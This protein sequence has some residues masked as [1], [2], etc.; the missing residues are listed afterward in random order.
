MVYSDIRGYERFRKME[1]LNKGLS[2]DRKFYIETADGT[3]L[4]LRVSDIAEH[5][6]KLSEFEKMQRVYA[7]GVPMPRPVDFGV[8][9]DGKSVYKLLT[10]IDGEN[11]EK[12]LPALTAIEQYALGVKAGDALR[13]IHSVPAPDHLVNWLTR[14]TSE[15]DSRLKWYPPQWD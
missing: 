12:A 3:R 5:D 6:R 11:A 10:W 1:P 13:K 2:S 4:L 8:C 14:Y 7:L 15:I 9:N